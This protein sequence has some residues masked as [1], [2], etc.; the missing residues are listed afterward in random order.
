L[1]DSTAVG[2]TRNIGGVQPPFKSSVALIKLSEDKTLTSQK[3]HHIQ[4][5]HFIP[6]DLKRLQTISR[7][8][9]EFQQ[10]LL[11][12]FI[13]NAQIDLRM[14][15]EALY[16]EDYETLVTCAH[17]LK[18]SSGNVGMQNFPGLASNLEQKARQKNLEGC[19]E[20]VQT[21]EEQL[22]QAIA[23]IQTHLS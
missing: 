1:D 19:G 11:Q 18:G 16:Q 22:T 6:F 3:H 9:L 13:D 10:K 15:R 23:F 5:Q 8:K 20:L 17:R 2:Q 21:M 4:E 12:L 7:G 14:I